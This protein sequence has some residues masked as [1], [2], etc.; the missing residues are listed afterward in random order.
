M[1]RHPPLLR[2]QPA[3]E[4]GYA[5]SK[6]CCSRRFALGSLHPVCAVIACLSNLQDASQKPGRKVVNCVC[7][8]VCVRERERERERERGRGGGLFKCA[9]HRMCADANAAAG[10]WPCLG[11]GTKTVKADTEDLFHVQDT[12]SADAHGWC[13]WRWFPFACRTQMVQT[14]AAV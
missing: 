10:N 4:L 8:C 12:T 5:L 14:G 7:V 9:G 13:R 11:C 2:I 1:P 3:L 6:G